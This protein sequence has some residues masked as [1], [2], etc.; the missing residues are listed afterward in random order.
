MARLP[1]ARPPPPTGNRTR[2]PDCLKQCRPGPFS[3]MRA[4]DTIDSVVCLGGNLSV[5]LSLCV[6]VHGVEY[7]Q[8]KLE[9]GVRPLPSDRSRCLPE[10]MVFVPS[11]C[12]I[13]ASR[14]SLHQTPKELKY[15][16]VHAVGGRLCGMNSHTCSVFPIRLQLAIRSVRYQACDFW[17]KGG[18]KRKKKEKKFRVLV[19]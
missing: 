7:Y 12:E 13:T 17:V 6:C 5:F 15:W 3:D 19:Q 14:S 8:P 4:R 11:V 10:E 1:P 9:R 16:G 18:G 2:N